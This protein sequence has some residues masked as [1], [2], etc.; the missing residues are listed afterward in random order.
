MRISKAGVD[1]IKSFEG[2]RSKAYIPVKG[3]KWT[4]GYGFTKGVKEGDVMTRAQADV[5]L[6][7]EL[8]EY[9]RAVW[10]ATGGN[11]TQNQFDALVSFVYNVGVAGM[12]GSSVIKAH[13]R[14]DHLAAARAFALWNKSGGRVYA[15]LTRRRAAEAAL[16]LS[17]EQDDE[18]PVDV[19]PERPMR[20]SEIVRASTAAGATA[21]VAAVAEVTRSVSDIKDNV[22][23]LSDWLVPVLLVAVVALCA[24]VLYQRYTQRKG[25]W[26]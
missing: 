19:E 14:G 6:K 8:L 20:Q 26:T 24:Y 16:Y 15:G 9:E 11:V 18:P 17:N 12:R 1:L 23:S 21:T 22:S 2:F 13:N 5:R 10:A 7:E 4:I 3:D 25:G